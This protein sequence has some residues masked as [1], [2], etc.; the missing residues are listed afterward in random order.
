MFAKQ[1][2][3]DCGTHIEFDA[4]QIG[5]DG[6]T[7]SCPKCQAPV[8]LLRPPPRAAPATTSGTAE[9]RDCNQVLAGVLGIFLGWCGSH[10][11]YL[12]HR[13]DGIVYCCIALFGLLTFRVSTWVIALIGFVEGVRYLSMTQTEFENKCLPPPRPFVFGPIKVQSHTAVVIISMA[14]VSIIEPFCM[15]GAVLF[16]ICFLIV[17]LCILL[18]NRI[19]KQS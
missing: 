7:V 4:D 17:K 8:T 18:V 13:K 6:F 15:A 1:S 3:Q 19:P 16:V 10:K 11:F 9:K 12:G 14:L 2:C 5:N